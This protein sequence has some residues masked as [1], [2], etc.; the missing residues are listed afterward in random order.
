MI[1]RGK[2]GSV[3]KAQ[4]AFSAA[5]EALPEFRAAPHGDA[6]YPA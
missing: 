6:T 5:M 4:A 1:F 2:I 3:A